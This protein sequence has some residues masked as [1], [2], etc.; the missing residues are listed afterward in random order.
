MPGERPRRN[1]KL[2][3]PATEREYITVYFV[4]QVYIYYIIIIVEFYCSFN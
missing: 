2:L 3:R 4:L 1:G